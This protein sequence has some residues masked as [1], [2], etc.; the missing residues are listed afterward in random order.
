MLKLKSINVIN[1]LRQ[2]NFGPFIEDNLVGGLREGNDIPDPVSF[3]GF[4]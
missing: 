3:K 1:L 4:T 2:K